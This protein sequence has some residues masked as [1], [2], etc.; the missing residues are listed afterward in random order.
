MYYRTIELSD[1]KQIIGLWNIE[2]VNL[3]YKPFR[4]EQD[5]TQQVVR[6]K[7]FSRDG[8][9]VCLSKNES[10]IGFINMV[11]KKEISTGETFQDTPGYLNMLVVDSNYQ[12]QGI[13]STLLDLGEKYLKDNGKKE[14]TLSH[15]CPIKLSWYV[16]KEK[17]EHNKAPGIKKESYGLKFLKKRGYAVQQ[18]ELSYYRNLKDF[19]LA[20]EVKIQAENLEKEGITFTFFNQLRHSGYSEMFERLEDPS[21]YK[22]FIDGIQEGKDILVA[23]DQTQVCATAGTIFREENGR[24]FF[25][26]LAVDP[27]YQGRHIGNVLFGKLCLALKE[28][29]A[30]YMTLFVTKDNHARRIYERAGFK[31]VQEWSIMNKDLE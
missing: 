2:A 28:K 1:I 12:K 3:G 13:G 10:V 16:D 11:C 15:S 7:N 5:F 14:V 6:N 29:Q 30:D 24:G 18:E 20:D 4:D 26:A 21:F 23:V 25:S 31:V 9:I 17:H 19:T 8:F 22:K 27:L